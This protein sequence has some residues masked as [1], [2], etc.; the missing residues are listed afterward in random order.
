MPQNQ[1]IMTHFKATGLLFMVEN[2]AMGLNGVEFLREL[3]K[4]TAPP[5]T[6]GATLMQSK[7][8]RH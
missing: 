4:P 2:P 5:T 8:D 6:A 3:V 1:N 7:S